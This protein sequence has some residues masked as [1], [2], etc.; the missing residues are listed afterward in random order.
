MQLQTC[1]F[2]LDPSD[3]DM[4]PLARH[5]PSGTQLPEC[6]NQGM[7]LLICWHEAADLATIPQ[8]IDELKS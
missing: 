1:K 7:D 5:I 2:N 6:W 3:T 8:I 4:P